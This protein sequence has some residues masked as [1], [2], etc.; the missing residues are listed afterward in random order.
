[1]T[2]L[3]WNSALSGWLEEEEEEEV[4]APAGFMHASATLCLRLVLSAPLS[5]GGPIE[6]P[7]FG[8]LELADVYGPPPRRALKDTRLTCRCG[9]APPAL[10]RSLSQGDIYWPA[11]WALVFVCT[12]AGSDSSTFI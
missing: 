8:C 2:A 11:S 4:E 12:V 1:M 5:A 3:D 6:S 10:S 7:P 9:A